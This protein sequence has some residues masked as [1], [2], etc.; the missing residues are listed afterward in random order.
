MLT[1]VKSGD[2]RDHSVTQESQSC[3]TDATLHIR[4]EPALRLYSHDMQV[5][6]EHSMNVPGTRN[7]CLRLSR[8]IPHHSPKRRTE[9]LRR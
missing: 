3:K 2:R 5:R 4:E 1:V 8:H 9:E 6:C 7:A